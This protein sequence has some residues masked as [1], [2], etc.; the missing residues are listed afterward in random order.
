[1]G[2][3]KEGLE[4]LQKA[5]AKRPDPEIAAH[6][7]EVLWARGQRQDAEKVWRDASKGNPDNELLQATMKRFLR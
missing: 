3:A 5:F 7:G 1:M 4:F 2:N 6:I